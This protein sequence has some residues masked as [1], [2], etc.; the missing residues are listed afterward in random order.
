V[1]RSFPR[2]LDQSTVNVTQ[3][4]RLVQKLK[5]KKLGVAP[6][7][8]HQ[9]VAEV[10]EVAEVQ[11]SH[12]IRHGIGVCMRAPW[13]AQPSKSPRR[14]RQEE[15]YSTTDTSHKQVEEADLEEEELDLEA[16]EPVDLNDP[17]LDLN[18]VS[19]TALKAAKVRNTTLHGPPRKQTQGVSKIWF[20]RSLQGGRVHPFTASGVAT[21][22]VLHHTALSST[23]ARVGAFLSPQLPSTH[24]SAHSVHPQRGTND[25]HARRGV[26]LE[27]KKMDSEFLKHQKLPGETGFNYDVQVDF[28]LSEGVGDWDDEGED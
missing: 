9:R 2:N 6:P 4:R 16:E 28:Q 22:A 19:I 27:Q 11:D 20:L 25:S 7:S 10:A 12:S 14:T 1:L 3:I 21:I 24:A 5:D 23:V 15:D 17:N 8:P 26:G 18:K 13:R